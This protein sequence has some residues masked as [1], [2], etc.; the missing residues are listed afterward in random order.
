MFIARE[1]NIINGVI[2]EIGI[3]GYNFLRRKFKY[4][5]KAYLNQVAK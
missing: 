1:Y 2:P 4:G 5:V 3:L